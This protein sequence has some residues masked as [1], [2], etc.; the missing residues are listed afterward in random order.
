[1][2]PRDADQ[3]VCSLE[4]LRQQQGVCSGTTTVTCSLGAI[5]TGGTA[6]ADIVV[7]PTQP[8]TLSNSATV[9]GDVTDPNPANN[10]ALATTSVNPGADVP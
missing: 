10:T 6:T 8:G 5:G 7:K 2:V 3:Q 9:S 4:T 1:V